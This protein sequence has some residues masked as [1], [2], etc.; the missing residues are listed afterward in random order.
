MKE[1]LDRPSPDDLNSK[2]FNAPTHIRHHSKVLLSEP[3]YD[4]ITFL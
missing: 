3:A 2:L 4:P 1:A